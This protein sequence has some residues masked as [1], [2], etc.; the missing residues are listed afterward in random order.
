MLAGA[1]IAALFTS[2]I[3]L[4]GLVGL[5]AAVALVELHLA[6]RSA[7]TTT[8]LAAAL[9]GGA[10]MLGGSY[11]FGPAAQAAGLVVVLLGAVLTVLAR[12]AHSGAVAAIAAT[13]LLAAWVPL[14]ASFAGLLLA[15]E[16]GEWIVL[17]VVALSVSNDTGAYAV[18]VL[19]GRHRLAPRVSPGKS[20]EGA[21]GGLAA[22]LLVGGLLLS[23]LPGLEVTSA[24]ALAAVVVPAGVLG[25]LAESL[26]KRD[27]GVKDLGRIVPGHGGIMDRVDSILFAL[28]AA[29]VLL[30][31]F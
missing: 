6:L 8:A 5:L 18:G 2:P 25:D 20:W 27:L 1:L 30:L 21:V 22:A 10:V 9:L 26:V 13:V 7:G 15:R 11:L 17:A 24:L 29:T 4:M 31:F 12:A 16:H 19:W 3:L 23:R 14:L 28:P